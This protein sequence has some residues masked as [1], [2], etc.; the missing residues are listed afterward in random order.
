MCLLVVAVNKSCD[1]AKRN[2]KKIPVGLLL[3]FGLAALAAFD[4]AFCGSN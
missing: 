4:L 2:R 1:G 3:F